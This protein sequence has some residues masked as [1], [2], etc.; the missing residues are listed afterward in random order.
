MIYDFSSNVFIPFQC[1]YYNFCNQVKLIFTS[2]PLKTSTAFP[3]CDIA[4]GWIFRLCRLCRV[5]K[6]IS[7]LFVSLSDIA[8][9]VW[10]KL[11]GISDGTILIF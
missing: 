10:H 7:T 5:F 3:K 8:R 2:M 11:A 9:V 6:L 4:S 1:I